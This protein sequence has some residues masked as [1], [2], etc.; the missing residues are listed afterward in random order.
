MG[1]KNAITVK[2]L[3]ERLEMY[4][5]EFTIMIPESNDR[6]M[7]YVAATNVTKSANKNLNC[8]YINDV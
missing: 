1:N 5:E 6:V 4:P 7:S 8:V 3:R 2:E